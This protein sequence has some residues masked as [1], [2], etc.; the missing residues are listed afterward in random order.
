MKLVIELDAEEADSVGE[1]MAC[2][3]NM[4]ETVMEQA[5]PRGSLSGLLSGGKEF[6]VISEGCR[7]NDNF[8]L[9]NAVPFMRFVVMRAPFDKTKYTGDG[10]DTAVFERRVTIPNRNDG[11]VKVT[12]DSS[13]VVDKL[14][15]FL[16]K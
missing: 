4:I 15:R 5:P 12:G 10:D 9:A 7:T 6:M 2:I 11:I 14:R 3:S 8:D 1:A 16:K 13:S